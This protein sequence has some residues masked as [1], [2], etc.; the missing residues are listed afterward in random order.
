M[1]G[2]EGI[3]RRVVRAPLRPRRRLAGGRRAGEP[4]GARDRTGLHGLRSGAKKGLGTEGGAARKDPQRHR[5]GGDA[6]SRLL[7]RFH[8]ALPSARGGR[9][10][11]AFPPHPPSVSVGFL[12]PR[13]GLLSEGSRLRGARSSNPGPSEAPEPAG[14]GEPRQAVRGEEGDEAPGALALNSGKTAIA[15]VGRAA[16]PS[17]RSG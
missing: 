12:E 9:Q 10:P 2:A 11:G 13:L 4:G 16:G 6:V 7:P 8:R 5:D 15:E 14:G 17:S 1:G 3:G